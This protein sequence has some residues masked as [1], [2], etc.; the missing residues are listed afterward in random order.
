MDENQTPTVPMESY[1]WVYIDGRLRLA[2]E[3]HDEDG[4]CFKGTFFALSD[5]R[6]AY[7]RWKWEQW[8][9]AQD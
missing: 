4:N 9:K 8:M 2:Y 3:R 7:D 6:S 5:A 1:S